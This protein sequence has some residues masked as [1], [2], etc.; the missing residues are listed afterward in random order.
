MIDG[1]LHDAAKPPK[2]RE[3]GRLTPDGCVATDRD[4]R[5]CEIYVNQ[6]YISLAGQAP[7]RT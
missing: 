6:L 4:S 3:K 7:V 2:L 5:V 1:T